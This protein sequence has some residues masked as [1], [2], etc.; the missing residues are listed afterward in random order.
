MA[1][2]V[3]VFLVEDDV[4]FGSVL[5]DYLEINDYH[6]DWYK[7]GAEASK[8]F[9]KDRYDI[10][11]LDVML[12]GVDG[13]HVAK[14]IKSISPRIPIIFLTAK[15]LK[16]DVI[17]GYKTGADDYITKPFDSELLLYKMEAILKRKVVREPINQK[18]HL[19]TYTFDSDLRILRHGE[20]T[21]RLSPKE[22]A[23]LMMLLQHKNHILP[24][25][26]A[27][28][29]IWGNNDYFTARSMD[30]YLS[31]IR[32]YLKAEPS[33]EIENIHGSG[34]ILRVKEE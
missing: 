33:L 29:Q 13:Y 20:T 31:K 9:Q 24:R 23:L 8:Y 14:E 11:I 34:F 6:A 5:Q 17:R 22:S 3:K 16:E 32:K 30:V 19:G 26:E 21:I 12:P 2:K 27:L 25:E 4:N 10:C 18:Y 28:L 1:N 7:N 15:T